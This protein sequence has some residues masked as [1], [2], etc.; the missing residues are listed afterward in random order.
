MVDL[1]LTDFPEGFSLTMFSANT[2]DELL[3]PESFN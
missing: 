1:Y 3:L 2:A